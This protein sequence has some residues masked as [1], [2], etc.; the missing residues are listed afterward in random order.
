MARYRIPGKN[1]SRRSIFGITAIVVVVAAIVAAGVAVAVLPTMVDGLE[2]SEFVTDGGYT[3]PVVTAIVL[4]ND[5]QISVNANLE[6]VFATVQYSDGSTEQVALSEMVIEGLDLTAENVSSGVV[7][8]FGGFEQRVDFKVIPTTLTVTYIAGEGG[9]ID[10]D[11][12]QQVIAGQ[13]ATTVRAVPNAGYEFV[14]WT[15]GYP[16]EERRDR[17]IS[18]TTTLQAV[19]TRQTFTVVFFY[20]DGTTA[21][22]EKVQYGMNATDIPDPDEGE[23][24]M[25]GYRFAG[26]DASYEHITQNMEIHPIMV[27]HAIDLNF[28]ATQDANGNLGGISDIQPYYPIGEQSVLRLSPN[29]EREFLAWNITDMNGNVVTIPKSVIAGEGYNV[30]VSLYDSI[31]VTFTAGQTGT[32]GR[33]EYTLSFTIP[34]TAVAGSFEIDIHA[35]FAYSTSV[36][37]FTSAGATGNIYS[38]ELDY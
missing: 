14:R 4:E 8:N 24:R 13:D 27:K 1:Y 23:M 22:E 6:S 38:A 2:G 7:L 25:Y 34:E 26:W 15:D 17:N 31:S 3:R 28:T 35:D 18:K 11:L 37:A 9:S 12:V 33:N 19:F 20:P 16:E 29:T 32:E 5:G 36:I 21:R 10:G 30:S